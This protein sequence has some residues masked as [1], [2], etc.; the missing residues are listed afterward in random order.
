MAKN[1]VAAG[2]ADRCEVQLAYA[3]GVAHPVSVRVETFGTEKI[4]RADRELIDGT[5]TCVRAHS[6]S[7]APAPADLPEDGRLWA[8]RPRGPDFTWERTDKAEALREAAGIPVA[9]QVAA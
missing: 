3:I 5:S 4:G 7:P 8:L 6:A 2:L 1:V 9:T